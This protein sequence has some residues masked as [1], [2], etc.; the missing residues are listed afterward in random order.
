MAVREACV[1]EIL[2]GCCVEKRSGRSAIDVHGVGDE[3][4]G[5]VR[6]FDSVDV[7]RRWNR[8]GG[9]RGNRRDRR[10][11]VELVYLGEDGEWR[12]PVIGPKGVN[13]FPRKMG[14][15]LCV[16][17]I[18]NDESH[19]NEGGGVGTAEFVERTERF[20]EAR[21]V[22]HNKDVGEVFALCL[23]EI[24]ETWDCL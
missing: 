6:K 11:R 22:S 12:F 4:V 18:G 5:K 24:K 7:V 14:P 20:S 3:D 8:D 13:V 23:H 21:A 17:G 16:W 1:E 19:L 2:L 10:T 15:P 9:R